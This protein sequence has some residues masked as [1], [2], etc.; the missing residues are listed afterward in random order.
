MAR[1]RTT[2]PEFYTS[3]QVMGLSIAAR[4]AFQGLWVFCDDG[5]NHPASAKTLKAEICPSDDI[6][7]AEVQALVDEM[8]SQGLVVVY[9]VGAKQFWHVT[10]W[11][12]QRIE[13]PTYK[14]PKFEESSPTPR[15]E[16][17]EPSPTPRRDIDDQSTT[18][19]RGLD[20]VLEG[21]GIGVEGI[22]DSVPYGTGAADASPTSPAPAVPD[23]Q[24]LPTKTPAEQ[25]KSDAWAGAKSLLNAHGMPLAQTGAF[26]GKLAREHGDDVLVDVM[27]AAV[28]ERP[29]QPEAWIV[30]ACK[31][32]AA[33]APRKG[34]SRLGQQPDFSTMNYREGTLADG[35]LV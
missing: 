19:R 12:H 6:T 22:G 15:R 18:S 3:E 31:T 29:G 2:K 30:G 14:H 5:G 33:A 10:G 7:A 9:E 24:S 27:E 13:K 23:Q 21:M 4:F 34:T 17:A 16:V 1:I 28:A 25:R 32:R 26:L 8:I 35:S 11:H 20:P